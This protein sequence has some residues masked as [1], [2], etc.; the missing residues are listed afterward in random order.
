MPFRIGDGAE[1][2]RKYKVTTGGRGPLRLFTLEVFL[3]LWRLAER[4]GPELI[5]RRGAR[6]HHA[7]AR[8]KRLARPGWWLRQRQQAEA[9]AY[10]KAQAREHADQ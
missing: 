8:V 3:S 7:R 2:V 5:E 6:T 10:R 1:V 4:A 9:F